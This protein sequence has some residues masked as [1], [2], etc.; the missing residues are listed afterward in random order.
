[1]PDKKYIDI[2]IVDGSWDIDPGQ[3]PDYCSDAYSIAQ[4]VKHAIMESGLARELQAE[5]NPALR[6]DVLIRIEQTAESDDRII[7]GS[8]SAQE[9]SSG[10]IYL[11]ATAYE[12]G[13]ISTEVS[14]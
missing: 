5:R 13:D 1:M 11:T 12:F 10:L 4:D 2:K 3:Q 8:A 14:V 9:Q 6:A 7:P